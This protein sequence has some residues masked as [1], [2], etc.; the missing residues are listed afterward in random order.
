[1]QIEKFNYALS[2]F[3]DKKSCM[4]ICST[5]KETCKLSFSTPK[6]KTGT[7]EY[8]WPCVLQYGKISLFLCLT[9]CETSI[10]AERTKFAFSMAENEIYDIQTQS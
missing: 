1:M 10:Y 4:K 7:Y 5:K 9:S 3:F 2:T 6:Y 8:W